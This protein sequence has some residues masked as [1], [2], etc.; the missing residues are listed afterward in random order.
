M[1]NILIRSGMSPFDTFDA[2][3]IIMNNSIGGNVGNLIYQYSAFRTLMT[4]GTTITPDYYNFSPKRADE[5]NEKY[6]CYVIPLADAFRPDFVPSLRRYTSLIKKLKIP[7]RSEERRVGKES[8]TQG[9]RDGHVTGVQT[10]ALPICTVR[11]E[12]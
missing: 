4:E 2:P 9:I 1:K 8:N 12:H 10:C 6:D 5:I 11:S 7:V 3:H